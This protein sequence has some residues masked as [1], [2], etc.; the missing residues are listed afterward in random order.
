MIAICPNPYRDLD[1]KYTREAIEL[2]SKAGHQTVICPV[3]A[4]PDDEIIPKDICTYQL[5]KVIEQCSLIIVIGGD[6]TILS[7][8]REMR[9]NTIPILGVNLGTMG[10]LTG[11]EPDELGLITKAANNEINISRRMMID[12]SLVRDGEEIYSDRAF[13]DAVLHGYGDCIKLTAWSGEDKIN[14]FS[15][16]GIVIATPT[17]STGY[18]LSTGGPIVEPD[19]ENIII[20]PICAHVMGSR[21]FVLDAKRVVSVKTEKL[22]DRR[23]Y[24]SVDGNSVLDLSNGDILVV[25]KSAHYALM[26]NMGK[27]SFFEIAYEKLT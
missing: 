27:K 13:N 20:S 15:G 2:L 11:L 8:A 22:H 23:A 14:S 21:S 25:K 1:L 7:V 18:S 24:L 5:D 10:F 4:A 17:G 26:A 19:T 12:I 16:D 9:D 6:G 3:F